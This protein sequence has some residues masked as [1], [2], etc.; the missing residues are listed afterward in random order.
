MEGRQIGDHMIA[1]HHQ[2]D[3]IRLGCVG[4]QRDRR[5]GVAR[6]G[7]QQQ[8]RILDPGTCE[9]R[10]NLLRMGRIGNDDRRPELRRI[11]SASRGELEH[12]FGM[13]KRQQ[14]LR[15]AAAR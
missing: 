14:L 8:P 3:C 9:L 10:R 6:G 1:R 12:G 5:R 2:Q 15:P 11:R 4:R 7:F 13:G